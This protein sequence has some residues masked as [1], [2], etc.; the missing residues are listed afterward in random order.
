MKFL[1]PEF[2]P[3]SLGIVVII[4]LYLLIRRR[5]IVRTGYYRL[6][7]EAAEELGYKGRIRFRKLISILLATTIFGLL[8]IS[9]MHPVP[10]KYDA[11]TLEKREK[12]TFIVVDTFFETFPYIEQTIELQK[13]LR[14]ISVNEIKGA[15]YFQDDAGFHIR[16]FKE[17]ENIEWHKRLLFNL[18]DIAYML[19]HIAKHAKPGDVILLVTLNK[20]ALEPALATLDKYLLSRMKFLRIPDKNAST[21]AKSDIAITKIMQTPKFPFEAENL[22]ITVKNYSNMS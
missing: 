8:V 9:L 1:A 15:L 20:T 21:S 14:K 4:V 13:I 5:N 6:W 16:S 17:A 11:D 2:L 19:N 7:L 3:L 10:A 22:T 18:P 12:H